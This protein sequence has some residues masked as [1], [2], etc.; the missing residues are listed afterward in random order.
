MP[1]QQ[2]SARADGRFRCKYNDRYFYGKTSAE[3]LRKRDEYIREN[4]LGYDPDQSEKRF[5]E[6]G[7]EWLEVYRTEC[8]PR[9]RRQYTNIIETAAQVLNKQFIRQITATDIQRLFNSQ[10]VMSNSHI[11]KFCTTIRSIFR[12]AA[13]DGII[14]RSPAEMAK[15]PEGTC[16]GHRC[17]EKWEQDLIINTYAEHDFGICA[18]VMMF[19]GLRRGEVMYLNVDRDVNFEKKTITV[20]GAVSFSES[21]GNQAV[22]SEGKTKA[23]QRVIP[24]NDLLA[25]A[26]KG[27]HGLLCHKEDGSMMSKIGFTRKYDSYILFLE[28][29][30]NGC[31]RRWYGK[32][33]EHKKLIQENKNLPPWQSVDIRCHDFRVTYCTMCY[34]AGIPIKTLQ[35]WMGHSDPSMIMNIYAKLTSEKEQADAATINE[36]MKNRFKKE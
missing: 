20:N 5:L 19:A 30:I 18:M 21:N 13:L 4:T 26:L 15:R 34:E 24:M 23:A 36:F 25:D 33:K 22:E 17:L 9:Q 12:S 10:Q 8:N 2:L 32:T 28:T 29:K 1:R 16:K 35:A 6:Y 7:L 3:A 14:L 11:S 31:N 27:R